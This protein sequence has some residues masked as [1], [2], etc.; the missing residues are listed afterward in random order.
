MLIRGS[1]ALGSLSVVLLLPKFVLELFVLIILILYLNLIKVTPF[2]CILIV[3][4]PIGKCLLKIGLQNFLTKS[5]LY[6]VI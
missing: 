1:S 6:E 5:C 3:Y 2:Q 4:I